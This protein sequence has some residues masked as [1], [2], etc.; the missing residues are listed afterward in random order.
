MVCKACVKGA[1]IC[2]KGT[3]K[4]QYDLYS[5]TSS[6]KNTNSMKESFT[7]KYSRM[8]PASCIYAMYKYKYFPQ[9]CR[10]VP[11]TVEHEAQS[12]QRINIQGGLHPYQADASIIV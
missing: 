5:S 10:E 2:P 12:K 3:G 4:K 11:A 8:K 6:Y 7:F 9:L 1:E